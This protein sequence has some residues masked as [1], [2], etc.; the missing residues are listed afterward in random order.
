[1]EILNEFS[2]AKFFSLT[3][4]QEIHYPQNSAEWEKSINNSYKNCIPLYF[5]EK[6][7]EWAFP[8]F[9]VK[10][11][12]FGN[13]MI[14]M[15]FT[16]LG[17][18]LGKINKKIIEEILEYAKKTKG[19][20]KIE[21]RLN[22]FSQEN[23][24]AMEEL[25]KSGFGKEFKKNQIILKLKSE[26]EL[27]NSFDRITRKGIKKAE[28]SGL[29]LKWITNEEEL[30]KFFGLYLRNMKS[31]GTPNHSYDFFR[32]LMKMKNGFKGVNC[33][34]DGK[35]IGTL[36]ILHTKDYAY[37]AY[38]ASD[39]KDLICQPNDLIHWELIKWCAEQKIK[40]F[41]IGQCD[42][43]AKENTH[44]YGIYKFKK[45]W[46]G[47]VYNKYHLYYYFDEKDKIEE[48]KKGK[49]WMTKVWS[50]L[51]LPIIKIMGPKIASQLA[52]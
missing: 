1:M 10:S 23:K 46:T 17:G 33:Y 47:E 35:I 21:V 39:K 15:P 52:L 22:D 42:S 14:S 26:E 9:L 7:E 2:E 6:N 5:M 11:R 50:K 8:F 29:D 32:N 25:S 24:N 38:N 48:A 20:S 16:D 43:N 30:K 3:E 28:K 45:K 41:D 40:Y 4:S 44:D 31:F 49:G 37:A 51:P 27:W 13:R 19:I 34:K 18:P 36:I 12:I